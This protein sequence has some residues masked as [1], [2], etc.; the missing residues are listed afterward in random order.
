[1]FENFVNSRHFSTNFIEYTACMLSNLIV[2]A[3]FRVHVILKVN[4]LSIF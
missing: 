4:S 2:I 1:M 3:K